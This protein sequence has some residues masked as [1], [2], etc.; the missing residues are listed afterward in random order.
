MKKNILSILLVIL[1]FLFVTGCAINDTTGLIRIAN[2]SDKDAT[3]KIG[4]LSFFV[5]KGG[6]YEYWFTTE[7]KGKVSADGIS[8][9]DVVCNGVI[10][11]VKDKE[12][13]FK[14]GYGYD[15]NL[16]KMDNKYYIMVTYGTG[17]GKDMTAS[18]ATHTPF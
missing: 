14:V 9:D 3:V 17:A 7:T 10:G 13:T 11:S 2:V 5:A 8:I 15:I 18:D 4:N 1:V 16:A 6:T 12:A